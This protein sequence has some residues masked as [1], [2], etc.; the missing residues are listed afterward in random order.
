MSV[1]SAVSPINILSPFAAMFKIRRIVG[2]YEPGTLVVD[3]FP[4][5]SSTEKIVEA[6][7]HMYNL[8]D[9]YRVVV[10]VFVGLW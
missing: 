6:S 8:S 4:D 1:M 5:I 2:P 7:N 9:A 3:K 10:K